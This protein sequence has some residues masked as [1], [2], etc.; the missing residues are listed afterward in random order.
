MDRTFVPTKPILEELTTHGIDRLEYLPNGVDLSLFNTS[1]RSQSW[2]ERITKEDK[3]V[4][5]FVSRLVW[6]KDLA[7]LAEAYKILRQKRL[8]FEMVIVGDGHA[9]EEFQ[10]MMPGAHFLGYQSGQNLVESY[11]SS[12]IFVFPSTT[13]TFGLVTVEAM[14]SGLAPIAAKVGGAVGIIEEGRSGLFAQP[15]SG[16]DLADGVEH[17]ITNREMRIALA[18]GALRRSLDFSWES[19]LAQ[20]FRSYQSVINERK[21]DLARAA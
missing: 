10:E 16:E 7:V 3:P 8:D 9:R 15:F 5:L 1:H 12:D 6:E 21:R 2:R 19:I 18:N 13:E 4:V 17:L 14:A 20:L 11:A